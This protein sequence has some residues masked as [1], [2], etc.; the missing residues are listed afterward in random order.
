[1]TRQA[2]SDA[3]LLVQMLLGTGVS[4][5]DFGTLRQAGKGSKH[6]TKLEARPTLFPPLLFGASGTV[7]ALVGHFSPIMK[8]IAVL[9]PCSMTMAVFSA[10][11][12][13]P[14]HCNRPVIS[15]S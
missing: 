13:L 14:N 10:L 3:V 11:F 6:Q 2:F 4:G 9:D 8:L 1:M 15:T 5:R 7:S 12:S